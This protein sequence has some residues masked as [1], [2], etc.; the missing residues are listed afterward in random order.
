MQKEYRAKV[1][2][3]Q[4]LSIWTRPDLSYAMLILSCY[5][6]APGPKHLLAANRA[7]WQYLKETVELGIT[8]VSDPTSLS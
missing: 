8:Y 5:L 7:L 4:Y 2:G 3:L 1:G 6:H